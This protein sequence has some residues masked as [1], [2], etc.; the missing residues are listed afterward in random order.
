MSRATFEIHKLRPR[1]CQNFPS[2]RIR[3]LISLTSSRCEVVR[4]ERRGQPAD[5]EH[6]LSGLGV[7]ALMDWMTVSAGRESSS[8]RHP[9]RLS[10]LRPLQI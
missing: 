7:L 2:Q 6:S 5:T 1:A 4:R 8:I 9:A 10:E 3:R